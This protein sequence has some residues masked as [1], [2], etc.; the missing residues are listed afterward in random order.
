M[1]VNN[2]INNNPSKVNFKSVI[3][4]KVIGTT[5]TKNGVRILQATRPKNISAAMCALIK[6][7]ELR[8]TGIDG[9]GKDIINIFSKIVEDYIVPAKKVKT[10]AVVRHK[11]VDGIGYIF[12]GNEAEEINRLGKQLGPAKAKGLATL[13]SKETYE[14]KLVRD[15]YYSV[16]QA[17]INNAVRRLRKSFRIGA[18]P[19]PAELHIYADCPIKKDKEGKQKYQ[20]IIKKI[21]FE[22]VSQSD[23]PQLPKKAA[24]PNSRPKHK[25]E[26]LKKAV[27]LRSKAEQK[28]AP[29]SSQVKKT[30]EDI[31]YQLFPFAG[32]RWVR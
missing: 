7:L 26:P 5:Q 22:K 1:K 29:V 27:N 13:G 28:P 20:F 2:Q 4:V 17:Y 16:I 19:Q 9:V 21:S 10:G 15:D 12:T 11:V 3:P 14:V 18:K 6:I 32:L 25:P 30:A 8:S 24:N 31:Q 23:K